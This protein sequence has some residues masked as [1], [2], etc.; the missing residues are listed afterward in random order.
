M[1]DLWN[2]IKYNRQSFST[3]IFYFFTVSI[4]I[5]YFS[6]A[7]F[8]IYYHGR[9]MRNNFINEGILLARNL[10]YSL[11]LGV[12]TE[13]ADLMNGPLEGFMQY[14]D[15]IGARIYADDGRELKSVVRHRR[16]GAEGAAETSAED[17]SRVIDSLRKGNKEFYSR[18]GSYFE[19]WAPVSSGERYAEESFFADNNM[20]GTESRIIG[21][22]QIELT[23]EARD[24]GLKDVFSKGIIIPVILFL[25]G[26]LIAYFIVR[27]ITKPLNR[28]TNGV[29]IMGTTGKFQEVSVDARDE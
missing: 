25:P 3:K 4:L 14:N 8:F 15:A 29:K 11:R 12:F 28:L 20:S 19:F 21:F 1:M 24:R 27:G 2:F 6:F 9:I 13:N 18:H 7:A 23:T 10:A 17:R 16:K 26:W 22:V 5:I